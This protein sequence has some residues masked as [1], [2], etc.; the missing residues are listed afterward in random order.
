VLWYWVVTLSIIR[1]KI[2]LTTVQMFKKNLSY[3]SLSHT[4]YCTFLCK[5]VNCS[6]FKTYGGFGG[7]NVKG[8][9]DNKAPLLVTEAI[10]GD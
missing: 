9:P 8:A 7:L 1:L 5:L 6:P 3:F 2:R 10:I 4:T